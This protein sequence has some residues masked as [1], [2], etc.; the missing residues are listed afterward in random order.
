M[1]FN[2]SIPQWCDCCIGGAGRRHPTRLFQSHNGAIAAEA[3]VVFWANEKRFNPT[4]VRLLLQR[5]IHL[6]H[7]IQVSIPQWCD[8]CQ[9]CNREQ[10]HSENRFN[11]T[12]VRLL[13]SI[14][15]LSRLLGSL[16]QSHNGAIAAC[17]FP[18]DPLLYD[19]FQSHNGAIA[20]Q[21]WRRNFAV[22]SQFQS[23]N[24]AIA[25]GVGGRKQM[26]PFWVSIPQWCDCC[27]SVLK[28]TATFSHKVSIPQWCD[29]CP[30]WFNRNMR[31]Q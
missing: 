9:R 7:C 2:V 24:G 5:L 1:S 11:P 26:S 17:S 12:M 30:L 3:R 10:R 13:P 22:Q 29:C 25:A 23:H 19:E 20:A 14:R 8:C 16:F 31:Q 28:L 18:V 6:L 21:T 4:M 27:T 15:F